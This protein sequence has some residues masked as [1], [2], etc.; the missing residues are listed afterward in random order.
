MGCSHGMNSS[1]ATLKLVFRRLSGAPYCRHPKA[2]PAWLLAR[3]GPRWMGDELTG[4]PLVG[5][6]GTGRR[7]RIAARCGLK[8]MP[9][10]ADNSTSSAARE[11]SAHI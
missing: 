2:Q 4:M 11:P 7:M 10:G 6:G 5:D 8:R 9:R 1:E 3:E